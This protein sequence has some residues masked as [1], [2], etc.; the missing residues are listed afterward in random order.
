MHDKC[1]NYKNNLK[2]EN[3]LDSIIPFDYKIVNKK[4]HECILKKN[5][6]CEFPTEDCSNISGNIIHIEDKITTSDVRV[7]KWLTG[8]TVDAPFYEDE[9]ISSL[10]V[11][12]KKIK[13]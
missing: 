7:I 10:W 12:S 8:Y 9:H 13:R 11:K 6:I 2:V 5:G 1:M 3:N 4:K